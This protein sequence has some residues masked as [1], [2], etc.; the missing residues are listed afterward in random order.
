MP[1]PPNSFGTANLRYPAARSSSKSSVKNRFSRSY[2][3]ARFPQ[4]PMR[5]SDKV[6]LVVPFIVAVVIDVS[7]REG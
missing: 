5:S 3:A 2:V 4:R 1:A 6:S 7:F